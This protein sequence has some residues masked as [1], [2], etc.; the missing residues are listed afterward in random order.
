ME[1]KSEHGYLAD[2]GPN[3]KIMDSVQVDR[4]GRPIVSAVDCV[5]FSDLINGRCAPPSNAKVGGVPEDEAVNLFKASFKFGIEYPRN[6]DGSFPPIDVDGFTELTDYPL[7]PFFDNNASNTLVLKARKVV[8][9]QTSNTGK[10]KKRRVVVNWAMLFELDLSKHPT[11]RSELMIL[12]RLSKSQRHR[13]LFLINDPTMCLEQ[14]PSNNA[15]YLFKGTVSYQLA[16]PSSVPFGFVGVAPSIFQLLLPDLARRETPITPQ[17]F[18]QT[19]SNEDHG[20]RPPEVMKVRGLICM[21]LRYQ[22]E[23]VRWCLRK[24]GKEFDEEKQEVVDYDTH[25][26]ETFPPLGW[27]QLQS[28]KWANPYIG[29]ICDDEQTLRK[30]I[31]ERRQFKISN[32]IGAQGLLAEEMG[33]GK[34]IELLS[35]VLLNKRPMV[36]SSPVEVFDYFCS[37]S[38]LAA[39]TT[40]I[41]SPKSISKQW[42]DEIRQHSPELSILVYNG[43]TESKEVTP[44]EMAEYDIVITSYNAISSEIHFALYDPAR[45]TRSHV[46]EQRSMTNYLSPLM[47]IQFWRVVLDEVQMV[48]SS[49][50]NAAQVAKLIPRVHAWGVTGTPVTKELQDLQGILNFLRLEPWATGDNAWSQLVRSPGDFMTLFSDI[51]IRHTTAMVEDDIQLPPQSRNLCPLPFTTIEADNYNQLYKAFLVDC[52]LNENGERLSD[53]QQVDMS[54]MAA[55]LVRL[56]QACC[57]AKFGGGIAKRNVNPSGSKEVK[58]IDEIHSAMLDQALTELLTEQRKRDMSMLNR[59]RVLLENL[60]EKAKA[61][62]VFK[63]ATKSVEHTVGVLQENLKAAQEEQKKAEEERTKR[64]ESR[65][66]IDEDEEDRKEE[67][68]LEEEENEEDFADVV[69]MM[70][71]R[72]RNWLEVLH[73]CYFFVATTHYQMYKKEDNEVKMEDDGPTTAEDS[74]DRVKKEASEMSEEELRHQKL[75]SEYYGK[76]Q[77]IRQEILQESMQKVNEATEKLKAYNFIPLKQWEHEEERLEEVGF[78]KRQICL[79]IEQTK[80]VGEWRDKLIEFLSKDVVDESADPDGQEYE[81]SL[82]SQEYAFDYLEVFQKVLSDRSLFITGRSDPLLKGNVDKASKRGDKGKEKD[83]PKDKSKNKN[84]EADMLKLLNKRLATMKPRDYGYGVTWMA[85]SNRMADLKK[86]KKEALSKRGTVR[87][88]DLLK[89]LD[90]HDNFSPVYDDLKNELL[91]LTKEVRVLRGCY[92]RRVGYYKQLQQ[93]SDNVGEVDVST[94]RSIPYLNEQLAKEKEM[95]VSINQKLGRKRYLESLSETTNNATSGIERICIICQNEYKLGAWT[96]C[97]HEFCRKCLNKWLRSHGT[98]PICKHRI[99]PGEV[100]SLT[101][102]TEAEKV[103][104]ELLKAEVKMQ[105]DIKHQGSIYKPVEKSLISTIRSSAYSSLENFGT[106]L[107]HMMRHLKWLRL[108]EPGAQVVVFSQWA[109]MLKLFGAALTHNKF[110]YATVEHG[111]DLFKTDSSY[112]CF[113]LHAKSQS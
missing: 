52:N 9:N 35:L 86:A 67:L 3:F 11:L 88:E 85:L 17:E 78:E 54:K 4:E 21:L 70:A 33:L 102:L 82:N 30:L 81:D 26:A 65:M 24:E 93:M 53:D 101:H 8:P 108:T 98:C 89:T 63:Q 46:I 94:D 76:A 58:T 77:S 13:R 7:L 109:E 22:R 28:G 50:S 99:N 90:E 105:D 96:I 47:K 62:S 75:E 29:R 23:T 34:T 103:Q 110:R 74:K 15:N 84:D 42:S 60:K 27:F 2:E 73:R 92:N 111:M 39:K 83:S 68:E 44:E 20:V 37:R 1:K 100:Y 45:P 48:R 32:N 51:A 95:D 6:N 69:N 112:A 113:L 43:K 49:V 80:V 5:T 104:Q 16:V 25:A 40:L 57:H 97:G 72:L 87:R 106:K 12:A 64:E 36:K 66:N 31:E 41:I 91:Q 14:I 56:R 55:W 107:D 79:L 10:S 38:V 71:K 59:G 19:I 18:Y 61:L